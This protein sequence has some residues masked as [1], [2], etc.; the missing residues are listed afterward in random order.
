VVLAVIAA[1]VLAE[2]AM[3]PAAAP[4]PTATTQPTAAATATPSP[5]APSLSPPNT[6]QDIALEKPPEWVAQPTAQ[7]GQPT[8]TVQ[9]GSLFFRTAGGV[10]VAPRLPVAAGTPLPSKLYRDALDHYSLNYPADWHIQASTTQGHTRRALI[11]PDVNPTANVPGGAPVL[12]F[13]WSASAPA[14]DAHDSA[15][16]NLGAVTAG[17]VKGRLFTIGGPMG[18]VV[19]A[20]FPRPGGYLIL[21]ADADNSL[22]IAAFQQTLA[23]L[24]FLS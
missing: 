12:V 20:S 16:T 7:A 21:S 22:L 18:Y 2:H 24:R 14:F 1:A 23:S 3:A 10:L 13:G 8:A 6:D 4:L 9:P 17:G 5:T 15:F 11:P 19:T